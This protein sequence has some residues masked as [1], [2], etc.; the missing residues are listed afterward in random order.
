MLAALAAA[1]LLADR[2]PHP[3]RNLL[4]AQEI[5][6]G[7]IFQPAAVERDQA[8]IAAHVRPL[9][10]GHGEMTLAEQAA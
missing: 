7:G 1:K 4:R 8:L 6:M 9:V 10:D 3:R 2:D 5:F